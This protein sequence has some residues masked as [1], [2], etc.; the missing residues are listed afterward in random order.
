MTQALYNEMGLQDVLGAY[1]GGN[2]L[3][4]PA[5]MTGNSGMSGMMG[6]AAQAMANGLSSDYQFQPKASQPRE[7]R[8]RQGVWGSGFKDGG[9]G[10]LSGENETMRDAIANQLEKKLLG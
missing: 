1:V 8:Q 5:S 10:M 9:Y 3:A 4:P 6:S 2:R 7:R